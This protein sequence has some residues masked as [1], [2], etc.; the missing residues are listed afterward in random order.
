MIFFFIKK[1]CGLYNSPFQN[2]KKQR[3]HI[4]H[5]IKIYG[6]FLMISG[7]KNVESK[8]EEKGLKEWTEYYW[9]KTERKKEKGIE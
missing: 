5:T 9:E 1:A 8:W 2:K 6:A 4:S 7:V 3:L